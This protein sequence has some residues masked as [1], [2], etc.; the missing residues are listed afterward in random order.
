VPRRFLLFERVH[1]SQLIQYHQIN[2]SIYP[3]TSINA[4]NIENRFS[5]QHLVSDVKYFA[6]RGLAFRDDENVGSPTK[7]SKKLSKLFSN[8]YL[9]KEDAMLQATGFATVLQIANHCQISCYITK[10]VN[11]ELT[12]LTSQGYVKHINGPWKY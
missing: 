10:F 7:F 3:V 5:W 8:E 12:N 9:K 11:L 6:E 1:L 4:N 2:L